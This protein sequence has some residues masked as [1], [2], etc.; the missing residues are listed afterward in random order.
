MIV[1]KFIAITAFVGGMLSILI[2][3]WY[4]LTS[5]NLVSPVPT[6]REMVERIPPGVRR[7]QNVFLAVFIGCIVVGLILRY[8]AGKL[9]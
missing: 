4:M 7:A 5:G 3:G 1:L 9:N 2:G 8:L 6:Q